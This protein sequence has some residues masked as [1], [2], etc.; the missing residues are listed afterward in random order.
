M[1]KNKLYHI[2]CLFVALF[3]M[4]CEDLE[5]TYDEFSGDGV[6]RYTGKCSD[7]NIEPG[8]ERLRVS[9]RG[10]IDPHIEKVK[11]AYQSEQDTVL[12]VKY[13]LPK[14]FVETDLMDTV[15]L[16]NLQDAV[17]TV[18][19]SNVAVDGTESLEET[20][21]GRPYTEAHEDLRTFT[22]GIVNFYPVNDR[23]V[24]ILDS[25]NS[26]LKE[27]NL[28][29]WGTD[30]KEHTWNIYKNMDRN[31]QYMVDDIMF[32]LPDEDSDIE[33]NVGIDFDKPL[34]VE[35]RGLLTGCIDTIAFDPVTLS[36][37]ERV[38]SSGFVNVMLHKYGIDWQSKVDEVE[39]LELD[40]TL[41]TF[42][43]L[44]Y[45]PN[46]RKVIL[47]KNRYMLA[48][49]QENISTTDPYLALTTLYYLNKTRGV[50]VECYN[51]HYLFT[52]YYGYMSYI[53]ILSVGDP[54]NPAWGIPATPAKIDMNWLTE[55]ENENLG[56]MPNI[57]PLN[58][59]GWEL[60]C[61]DTTYNGN[62]SGGV[63]R[64]LDD[65]PAT[66]FE[67][68]VEMSLLSVTV[69]IDMKKLQPL[70][71]F[72]FVQANMGS[73][74]E[75]TIEKDLKYLLSSLKIEIS[76]NG[77]SWENATYDD[78]GVSLGNAIGETTFINIPE[79][80]QKD[81]Q[82]IRLSMNTKVIGAT[83]SGLPMYSL[84]IGDF[85]PF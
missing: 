72:K 56:E 44:F 38:W 10:N 50:E 16:E 20:S 45:F 84:R 36:L 40:Y 49:H 83:T 24:V 69:N 78:G 57:T 68:G 6:I 37:D 25:K 9:W 7:L 34:T 35:R 82:Y 3:M 22:R 75:E 17:Y 73:I 32:M 80:K 1:M 39:V 27:I 41:S 12:A 74:D 33:G 15:Y 31:I 48:D 54:G 11:I 13:M 59:E 62:K 70:H 2:A 28:K 29:Y 58:T 42:Q 81:V 77:Y 5:D 79:E 30:N 4:G 8:W 60:T 26:N 47:G 66:V 18:K 43:D 63:A 14:D 67:P 65:N 19:V 23:L 71:G 64:M 61:S 76:T 21:Y 52:T 85:I 53:E 55:K 46:L 51:Q